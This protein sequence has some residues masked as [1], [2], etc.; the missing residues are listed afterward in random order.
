MALS[1]RKRKRVAVHWPVR[2]WRQLVTTPVESTTE[3]LSSEGLYCITK[4]PFRT[5]E[6]LQCEIVIPG[7]GFGSSEPFLRLQC[8]VT[9]K[10]VEPVHRGF[11]LG[12]HIEDYSV[13]APPPAA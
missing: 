6:R 1:G 5:G 8:H 4:E 9:V 7:E 3:N 11:G 10:R 13:T 12:C 2:L